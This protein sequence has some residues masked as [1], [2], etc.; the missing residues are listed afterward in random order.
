MP[1]ILALDD[2]D[3]TGRRIQTPGQAKPLFLVRECPRLKAGDVTSV[4]GAETTL[5]DGPGAGSPCPRSNPI[6]IDRLFAKAELAAVE[7][8]AAAA[9]LARF[10]CIREAEELDAVDRS[11]EAICDA[12][13]VVATLAG[14]NDA[15]PRAGCAAA[16]VARERATNDVVGR[17]TN[18]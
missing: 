14:T 4:L 9:C 13:L 7:S 5:T 3:R 18:E 8:R 17:R 6:A 10:L 15:D 12:R 11:G 1:D 2:T 16:G